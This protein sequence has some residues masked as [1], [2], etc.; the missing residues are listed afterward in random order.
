MILHSRRK[1][2][3][4]DQLYHP[5][6]H[7]P[8]LLI[9]LSTNLDISACSSPVL[10]RRVRFAKAN[11]NRRSRRPP[12]SPRHTRHG[13]SASYVSRWSNLFH[14]LGC[15]YPTPCSAGPCGSHTVSSYSVMPCITSARTALVSN[16]PLC[17]HAAPSILPC[18]RDLIRCPS[19][20]LE[21]RGC[22]IRVYAA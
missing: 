2:D 19:S 11:R 5:P 4:V 18:D 17:S 7:D 1:C 13:L 8:M 14:A 10:K 15:R 21:G 6:I 16:P 20:S 9:T 22:G 12:S 3:A